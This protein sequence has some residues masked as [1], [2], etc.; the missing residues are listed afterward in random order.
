MYC[1]NHFV[2]F[3]IIFVFSAMMKVTNYKSQTI[4]NCWTLGADPQ[5]P[6]SFQGPFINDVN[7]WR[8]L[9]HILHFGIIIRGFQILDLLDTGRPQFFKFFQWKVKFW[10]YLPSPHCKFYD[11]LFTFPFLLFFLDLR[12]FREIATFSFFIYYFGKWLQ[13]LIFSPRSRAKPG[14]VSM[15][16]NYLLSGAN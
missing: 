16:S 15:D 4:A 3:L 2:N 12:I 5:S 13:L 14:E 10:P 7:L 11:F 9:P 1:H 6:I 8:P